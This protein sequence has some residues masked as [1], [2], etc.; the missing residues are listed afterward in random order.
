MADPLKSLKSFRD[1]LESSEANYRDATVD[2][3]DVVVG[4]IMAE[5]HEAAG[6]K[7]VQVADGDT[8]QKVS[9]CVALHCRS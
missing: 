6:K 2:E 5:I 8:L 9:W 4:E 1:I 7:R 3:R